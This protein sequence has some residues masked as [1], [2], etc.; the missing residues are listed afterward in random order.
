MSS[1]E[2]K[3]KIFEESVM[4][5]AVE[6]RNKIIAEADQKISVSIDENRKI[7]EKEVE[8]FHKKSI[9]EVVKDSNTIISKVKSEGRSLIM[10]KRNSIVESVF[11]ELADRML[12]FAKT[13]EYN[14][15]FTLKLEEALHV[16]MNERNNV[17]SVAGIDIL[18]SKDD[19]ESKINVTRKIASEI[20]IDT[21]FKIDIDSESIIGG[22]RV[23][24]RS[25]GI[26]IDNS[27]QLVIKNEKDQFL[28]WSGL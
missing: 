13:D 22:C 26:M 23:Y 3:L 17:S 1:I 7:Y 10:K 4:Q 15:F 9:E 14:E 21:Q 6:I 11:N 8:M 20:L 25:K 19:Y 27:I 2:A 12:K 18:L 16:I 24:S 28:Q 5:D